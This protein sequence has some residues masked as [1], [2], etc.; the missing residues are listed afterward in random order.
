MYTDTTSNKCRRCTSK[1][2]VCEYERPLVASSGQ[3]VFSDAQDMTTSTSE[4]SESSPADSWD[5]PVGTEAGMSVLQGA[6]SPADLQNISPPPLLAD[7]C[8]DPRHQP[9]ILILLHTVRA[10][11]QMMTRR[12]TFPAFIHGHW[13]MSELPDALVKC[14]SIS[15][16]CK[17]MCLD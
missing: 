3:E 15:Q 4:P 10:L 11:P 17:S 16:L 7:I 8:R 14:M 1:G 13:H 2:L 5:S 6:T 9:T 12:E